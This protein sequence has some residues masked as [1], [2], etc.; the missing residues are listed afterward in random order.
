IRFAA[1]LI[2]RIA[3]GAWPTFSHDPWYVYA[4]WIVIGIL[5]TSGEEVGWRGYA[6]PRL[7]TRIGFGWAS[8]VVGAAWALWH[9]PLFFI[10]PGTGN[11]GQSFPL[12]FIG[13]TALS[14]AIGWLFVHTKGSVLLA[15]LMHSSVNATHEI[16]QSGF[17][18]VG[19]F[20]LN[21]T[22][23][24]WLTILLLW[25]AAAYF[26]YAMQKPTA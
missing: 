3:T 17:A 25:I 1:A 24:A 10:L 16:V 8:V 2:A 21:T 13:T 14:V 23:I 15:M 11:Y 19:P 12:F 22:P 20:S 9:F 18:I 26:L 5:I 7:G 6:L 4:D